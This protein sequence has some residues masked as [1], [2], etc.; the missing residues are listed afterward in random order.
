[1][2]IYNPTWTLSLT[3]R[4]PAAHGGLG[5]RLA[6]VAVPLPPPPPPPPL[7]LLLLLLLLPPPPPP[8]PLLLLRDG[9]PWLPGRRGW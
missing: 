7:L 3:Q 9:L 1:M 5:A 6:R 8:P 4:T 2:H